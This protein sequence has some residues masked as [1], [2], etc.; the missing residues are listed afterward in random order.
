MDE[1]LK[2]YQ[3]KIDEAAASYEAQRDEVVKE[4][5]P[6]GNF[7]ALL[8]NEIL[9]CLDKADTEIRAKGKRTKEEL[10]NASENDTYV[11]FEQKKEDTKK[12]IDESAS[13][14]FSDLDE[15][16]NIVSAQNALNS[17]NN[18]LKKQKV[19]TVLSVV[20]TIN[21][22]IA[23]NIATMV[24][25]NP[26]VVSILGFE[27]K[28]DIGTQPGLEGI[29][30]GSKG[31]PGILSY[32]LTSDLMFVH[33]DD[34]LAKICDGEEVPAD[35]VDPA[36]AKF[37]NEVIT[38]KADK[39]T[40]KENISRLL[41]HS[42]DSFV[43][44]EIEE[45]AKEEKDKIDSDASKSTAQKNVD[46]HAVDR[47]LA[48]KRDAFL[49]T[50][51]N[52]QREV[53]N[54][55]GM[56]SFG[57]V[58][59][60]AREIIQNKIDD[61]ME[62]NPN[63]LT[64]QNALFQ[65]AQLH[66]FDRAEGEPP[67]TDGHGNVYNA[68]Y[69]NARVN[70][71][72]RESYGEANP[73]RLM[74]E[75][76]MEIGRDIILRG[77]EEE[78]T[79]TLAEK[80]YTVNIA[81]NFYE[82]YKSKKQRIVNPNI[83]ETNN[84]Q[85]RCEECEADLA[86]AKVEALDRRKKGLF[87]HEFADK[88]EN[89]VVVEK[90]I[91][92]ILDDL[93]KATFD[94]MSRVVDPAKGLYD[95]HGDVVRTVAQ[96]YGFSEKDIPDTFL[97]DA[98]NSYM[99]FEDA[100]IVSL[101]QDLD[102]KVITLNCAKV[103]GD[104]FDEMFYQYKKEN[105]SMRDV[106]LKEGVQHFIMDKVD[107]MRREYAE[108]CAVEMAKEF[109]AA[110]HITPESTDK[111][112]DKLL[113]ESRKCYRQISE[114]TLNMETSFVYQEKAIEANKK[115]RE[116]DELKVYENSK[117]KL[118][119]FE[120]KRIEI[121]D[122]IDALK[123]SRGV[124]DPRDPNLSQEDKE[125]FAPLLESETLIGIMITNAE[126]NMTRAKTALDKFVSDTL[127]ELKGEKERLLAD[128]TNCGL[129]SDR[130]NNE[131]IAGIIGIETPTAPTIA[132]E[133]GE[134]IPEIDTEKTEKMDNLVNEATDPEKGIE[135]T[136]ETNA[137]KEAPVGETP[138]NPSS[139]ARETPATGSGLDGSGIST[140]EVPGA[141]AESAG[142]TGS[143]TGIGSG[144]GTGSSA[145]SAG[146]V[147]STGRESSSGVSAGVGGSSV[148]PVGGD[149]T[150]HRDGSGIVSES[151]DGA[152]GD[153]AE[154]ID[155][156][157][158][159]VMQEVN[160]EF[161]KAYKRHGAPDL[162]KL[163]KPYQD[164]ISKE[165]YINRLM[166]VHHRIDVGYNEEQKEMVSKWFDDNMFG[167]DGK[168]ITPEQIEQNLA[169]PANDEAYKNALVQQVMYQELQNHK[170]D[171][172]VR[173]SLDDYA[174]SVK[175]DKDAKVEM[176]SAGKLRLE[177]KKDLTQAL[178]DW[179]KTKTASSSAKA[180]EIAVG[181]GYGYSSVD[182]QIEFYENAIKAMEGIFTTYTSTVTAPSS[183]LGV[184][185]G[186]VE[187]EATTSIPSVAV[188]ATRVGRFPQN[189]YDMG[190]NAM[191]SDVY[192]RMTALVDKDSVYN[193][194][195]G[196]EA[197]SQENAKKYRNYIGKNALAMVAVAN[198]TLD[199]FNSKMKAADSSFKEVSEAQVVEY[200][201]EQYFNANK[202]LF[203]R[204]SIESGKLVLT[205]PSTNPAEKER[206]VKDNEKLVEEYVANNFGTLQKGSDGKLHAVAPVGKESEETFAKNLEVIFD[207]CKDN[208]RVLAR[209]TTKEL[210]RGRFNASDPKMADEK[211]ADEARRN[212]HLY[213]AFKKAGLEF[214]S[215]KYM[216]AVQD[217]IKED[218]LA[219]GVD[220]DSLN[221]SEK[222]EDTLKDENGE[223]IKDADGNDI[224]V[225]VAIDKNGNKV[226]YDARE[227]SENAII[228]I[229]YANPNVSAGIIGDV[230]SNMSKTHDDAYVASSVNKTAVG[231]E[232]RT[233]IDDAKESNI[234]S[235]RSHLGL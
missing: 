139:S 143:S 116:C 226:Y 39:E 10:I 198:G 202:N 200:M 189:I 46:K 88:V 173:G 119:E 63:G 225:I 26:E 11:N 140:G 98:D 38:G 5:N 8:K 105:P 172:K 206:I 159:Q 132:T 29:T 231:S 179:S 162:T 131:L 92:T 124:E 99:H 208:P 102:D 211:I 44:R 234:T 72:A 150:S 4:E 114:N 100:A 96:K 60:T 151:G 134:E 56:R 2:K 3:D 77:T 22:I 62:K 125:K 203:I 178:K 90:G 137:E 66:V 81:E 9:D 73:N 230:V 20:E 204:E 123:K 227:G 53:H 126:K 18:L 107:D 69:I 220:N 194:V 84:R 165:K 85:T 34:I 48:E 174:N 181:G 19:N 28:D 122:S 186:R 78:N 57:D 94:I 103:F 12:S 152:S 158:A 213:N 224:P 75:A 33:D 205:D 163:Q 196:D 228:N 177:A 93:S 229:D 111:Y 67:Y 161:E 6:E 176:M 42:I 83:R 142:G 87:A 193:K 68:D 47:E 185:G 219:R 113:A 223:T 233:H 160:A 117:H 168:L 49:G 154:V 43:T 106:S 115:I 138:S 197:K 207:E 50:F 86:N 175:G 146:S 7:P 215:E 61:Y 153:T 130:I 21:G 148:P 149:R 79:R 192:D 112:F 35:K 14:Y 30:Y 95:S 133:I 141:G 199:D 58:N 70:E 80:E 104:N 64:D 76:L 183:D 41:K 180:G 45:K 17:A 82:S 13:K 1:N 167:S 147:G 184:P 156:E 40:I 155:G 201:K 110:E 118:E 169:H 144:T 129:P 235:D 55:T 222:V 145:G 27:S 97:V 65:E 71:L 232:I 209:V 32:S 210:L 23:D 15:E 188:E 109:L 24:D 190:V 25:N 212:T 74:Y 218:G 191:W 51:T 31:K 135:K 221:A 164:I 101:L 136:D 127:D 171:N 91:E 195:E 157:F 214:N 108:T 187:T 128:K 121:I 216:E 36:T 16:E 52:Y 37:I 120:N 59:K 54:E 166:A 170:K 217:K 89:N 182:V